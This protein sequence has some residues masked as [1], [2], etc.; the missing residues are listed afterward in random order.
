[1]PFA[2]AAVAAKLGQGPQLA[3]DPGHVQA[4]PLRQIAESLWFYP[5]KT[6]VPIHLSPF[7]SIG[8]PL[9]GTGPLQ[10][11][12]PWA[13]VLAAVLMVLRPRSPLTGMALAYVVALAPN[14]GLVRISAQLAGD[15]YVFIPTLAVMVMAFGVRWHIPARAAVARAMRV[16]V[17]AL[18]VPLALAAVPGLALLSRDYAL[19]WRDSIT[20]WEHALRLGGHRAFGVVGGLGQ[21]Y[22][23]AGRFEDSVRLYGQGVM[24][25]PRRADAHRNYGLAL[26]HAGRLDPAEIHLRIAASL[27]PDLPKI[28]FNLGEVLYRQ[29][30]PSQALAALAM[31]VAREP[32]NR[33]AR[34]LAVD[35]LMTTPDLDPRLVAGVREALGAR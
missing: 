2:A 12:A 15:R 8:T 31:A 13:T 29:E 30:K 5:L 28:M 21:A 4:V 33:V 35:L 16:A 32:G 20:L 25:E 9:P 23:L 24:L 22:L 14:L 26:A 18:G 6:L 7:Y 34:E 19:V 27:N 1:L 3:V 17:L 10:A 11:V